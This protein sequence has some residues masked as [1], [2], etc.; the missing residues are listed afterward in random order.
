MTAADQVAAY[1]RESITTGQLRAG[2]RLDPAWLSQELD[3]SRTPVREAMLQLESE[4]LLESLPSRATIVRR[5]SMRRVEELFAAR[6]P[7]EGTLAAV[8][9][10][11]IAEPGIAVLSGLYDEMLTLGDLDQREELLRLHDRFLLGI[12]EA[13]ASENLL[14]IARPLMIQGLGLRQHFSYADKDQMHR[15]GHVLWKEMLDACRVHDGPGCERTVRLQLL[16]SVVAILAYE[17]TADE[18]EYLPSVLR[19]AELRSYRAMFKSRSN[20]ARRID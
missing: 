9:A 5:V 16:E 6:I 17:R 3:V 15:L 10:V 18:L 20:W 11:R 8:G 13:A 7:V 19:P 1:I 14:R 2:E 4:G 12:Y